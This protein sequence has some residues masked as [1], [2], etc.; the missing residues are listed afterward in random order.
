MDS[1]KAEVRGDRGLRRKQAFRLAR[2]VKKF[3]VMKQNPTKRDIGKLAV[4]RKQCNCHACQSQD[5]S[6]SISSIKA[7]AAMFD[8]LSCIGNAC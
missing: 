8:Q 1:L 7:D 6:K 2:V 4:T 5:H 3:L